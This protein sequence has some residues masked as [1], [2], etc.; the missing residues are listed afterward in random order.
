RAGAVFYAEAAR[1]GAER[2]FRFIGAGSLIG[3][4]LLLFLV[5]RS[6]RP[7]A[8]G[9]VSVGFGIGAAVVVT[10]SV[11]G[12]LHLITL[13]FG[14][15]LIGEAIDYSIQYF[16]AR[17]AAG[18]AW[19]PMAG[20][21]RVAPALSL[22]FL[23]SA[24]SYLALMLSPFPALS[25]IALF[26]LSGLGA[27]GLTVFLLLP[28]LLARPDRRDPEA[29]VALPRRL[30]AAWRARV[31]PRA[32]LAICAALAA[33]AAPGALRLE[34][35]DDVRLLAARPAALQMQEARLRELSGMTNGGR[36]FLVA[37]E[38][39]E[40][41][42][43]RGEALAERLAR[44]AEEGA[45]EGYS[46]IASFV[47]SRERQA[48]N[49]ALWREAV[50]G[51]AARLARLFSDMGLRDEIAGRLAGEFRD[52]EGRFL[53]LGDWL[54][55]PLSAP[56]RHLWLGEADGRAASAVLLRG[57]R[58][59][60]RLAAAASPGVAF[61]DKAG[62]VSRLFGET[63]R[64]GAGWLLGALFLVYGALCPRFG[65][66]AAAGVLAPA[67]LGL[68]LAVGLFGYL[69]LPFTLFNLMGLILSLGVGVNYAI[70]LKEGG[71]NSAAALAGALLSAATTLLSFGLLA[72]SSMPA[73]AGFGLTL[74]TAVGAACLLTPMVLSFP[75]AEGK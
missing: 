10:V 37:G 41:M 66:R 7:L 4:L 24:L 16:A 45:L 9:L 57:E 61:V 67:A 68:F 75:R 5:F 59:F 17:L 73:L 48:Q 50:F 33:L 46:G 38:N 12:E 71:E 55:S 58:D 25:Q 29:A 22:A 40:E 44:L 28:A 13:V 11:F 26:A 49:R 2:D 62:S 74:L 56:F 14:A 70:F 47:P 34:A 51:D 52:S 35:N 3:L 63:R 6:P 53:E 43:R 31:G 19:E 42:L 30:L 32:A 39:R 72:F 60:V 18:P 64:W 69:G 65:A 1:R 23:T 20:L 27:A 21:R 36:F 8:L 15:S 54:A